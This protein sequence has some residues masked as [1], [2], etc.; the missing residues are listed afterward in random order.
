MTGDDH[1]DDL[2]P[3]RVA[4]LHERADK[5]RALIADGATTTAEKANADDKLRRLLEGLPEEVALVLREPKGQ[6]TPEHRP[7]PATA[8][9]PTQEQPAGFSP[10]TQAPG[11]AECGG[12]GYWSAGC[13][14]SVFG[15]PSR[16]AFV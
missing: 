7:E 13:A 8:G 6:P 16:G 11:P 12:P 10:F 15:G 1:G 5:L 9:T 4:W 2:T 14:S 3:E